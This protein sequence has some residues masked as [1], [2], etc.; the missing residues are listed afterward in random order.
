M[1]TVKTIFKSLYCVDSFSCRQ[2][3][4]GL[5]NALFSALQH[6]SALEQGSPTSGI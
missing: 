2:V 4:M 1:V 6:Q 3:G 5:V